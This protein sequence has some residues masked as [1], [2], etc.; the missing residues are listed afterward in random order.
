MISVLFSLLLSPLS[1]VQTHARKAAEANKLPN[2][3]H[4]VTGSIVSH[5]T[6]GV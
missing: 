6:S 3:T 2:P 5:P 1:I 4:H